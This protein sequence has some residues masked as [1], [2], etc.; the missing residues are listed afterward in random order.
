MHVLTGHSTIE[1]GHSLGATEDG[2]VQYLEPRKNGDLRR[3][4]AHCDVIIMQWNMHIDSLCIVMLYTL[5]SHVDMGEYVLC[6]PSPSQSHRC[7][8]PADA[9]RKN[10]I[11]IT[12][13]R[14]RDA[15]LT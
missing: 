2:F 13:K 10:N 15:V 12:S 14:R 11:I 4:G 6:F 5:K 9:W 3:P 1:S 7:H 8:I